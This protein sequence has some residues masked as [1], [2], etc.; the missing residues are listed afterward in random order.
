MF[1]V[2]KKVVFQNTFSNTTNKDLETF[3][4]FRKA[5]GTPKIGECK[6]DK[7][8]DLCRWHDHYIKCVQKIQ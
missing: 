7:Y 6:K 8:K 5:D 4:N 2:Q 1:L 3:C